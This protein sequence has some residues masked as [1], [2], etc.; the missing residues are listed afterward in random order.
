MSLFFALS[1][2]FEA[3]LNQYDRIRIKHRFSK[4]EEA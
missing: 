3:Y 2:A 4:A 1:P